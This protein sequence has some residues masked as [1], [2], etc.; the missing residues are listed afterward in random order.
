MRHSDA[1]PQRPGIRLVGM[2]LDRGCLHRWRP[3]GRRDTSI[4]VVGRA[5]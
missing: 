4:Q 1:D 2:A 3:R 5:S